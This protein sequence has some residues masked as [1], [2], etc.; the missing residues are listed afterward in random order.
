[1]QKKLV[2]VLFI[3]FLSTS[4]FA[5]DVV[6][7]INRDEY[8]S[9]ETFSTNIDIYISGKKVKMLWE[10]NPYYFIFRGDKD[11]VWLVDTEKKSYMEFDK[12]FIKKAGNMMK[13]A[14]AKMEESLANLPEAQRK[15]AEKMMKQRMDKYK[16]EYAVEAENFNYVSTNIAK[17]IN[18]YPCKKVEVLKD[19]VKIEELWITGWDK[20]KYKDEIETGYTSMMNFIDSLK[21]AFSS[22]QSRDF[23]HTPFMIRCKLGDEGKLDGYPIYAVHYD[24]DDNVTDKTYL[25]NIE[26]KNLPESTFT[27]P[28]DFIQKKADINK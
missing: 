1:M 27:P 24:E 12:E 21:T 18:N 3:V 28:A 7:N 23:L 17:K 8:S 13:V 14:M 9:G 2:L 22:G 5:K 11:A 25:K 4:L 20:F 26:S 15:M 16:S 6:I 10:G 19:S